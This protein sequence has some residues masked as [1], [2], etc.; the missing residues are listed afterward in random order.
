MKIFVNKQKI[1][2]FDLFKKISMKSNMIT[3]NAFEY[4]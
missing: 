4:R 1:E 2:I 3:I